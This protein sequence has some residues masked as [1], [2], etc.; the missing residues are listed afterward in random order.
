MTNEEAFDYIRSLSSL[1]ED[2]IREVLAAQSKQ[3]GSEYIL[4]DEDSS[5][6][7]QI[8]YNEQD[9]FIIDALFS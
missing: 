2:K 7:F 1:E 5:T 9:G 4:K 6:S 3:S 8:R